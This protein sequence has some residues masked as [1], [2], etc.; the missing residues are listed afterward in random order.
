MPRGA[1]LPVASL[2]LA[3]LPL[4]AQRS[5][6]FGGHGFSG[7]GFGGH[8]SAGRSSSGP[9]HS[10]SPA[11][12]VRVSRGAWVAHPNS[13]PVIVHAPVRVGRPAVFP[14]I[15][16]G[17]SLASAVIGAPR[18]VRPANGTQWFGRPF[19]FPST[20]VFHPNG[21][22]FDRHNGFFFGG[23]FFFG[24]AFGFSPFC[25]FCGGFQPC[26]FQPFF[27]SPFFFSPFFPFLGGID[28]TGEVTPAGATAGGGFLDVLPGSPAD[29]AV[30]PVLALK[31][32]WTYEVTDYW[33]ANG[34][35]HYVTSYGGENAVPFDAID[36]DR[37][38]QQ[39]SERG[40]TFTLR[41]KAKPRPRWR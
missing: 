22:F 29:P 37:T 3:A 30:L 24:G 39:N 27:G 12:A 6:G 31:N 8:A 10:A 28:S 1:W 34:Q 35:L 4:Q 21:F 20:F 13:A 17:P 15:V 40:V 19:S 23:P 25:G 7:H 33:V 14:H 36:F 18:G 2:L 26:F 38:T 11:P 32:G 9:A 5:G 41:P 16:S